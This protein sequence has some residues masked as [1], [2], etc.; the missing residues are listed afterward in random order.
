MK[1]AIEAALKCL[2]EQ[3]TDQ[4]DELIHSAIEEGAGVN[5]EDDVETAISV[6]GVRTYDECGVLTMDK[7]L[8]I[9]LSDGSCVYLTIQVQ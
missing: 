8:A 2:L 3:E 7:G 6:Q 1:K 9:S 5:D 4:L